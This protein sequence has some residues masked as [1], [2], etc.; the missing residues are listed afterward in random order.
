[1]TDASAPTTPPF[2]ERPSSLELLAQDLLAPGDELLVDPGMRVEGPVDTDDVE[3]LT[4][5]S[6]DPCLPFLGYPFE[7]RHGC[8]ITR[9]ANLASSRTLHL[10]Q[11]PRFCAVDYA[12]GNAPP[13]THLRI[14]GNALR[15]ARKRLGLS[16]EAVAEQTGLSAATISRIETGKIGGRLE[17]IAQIRESLHSS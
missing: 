7:E 10:S 6:C 3:A 16:L 13:V 14:D 9:A 8:A 12:R 5:G 11:S 17:N 1:M 15:A 2:V 4:Q